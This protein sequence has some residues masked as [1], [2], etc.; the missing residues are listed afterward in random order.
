MPELPLRFANTLFINAAFPLPSRHARTLLPAQTDLNLVEVF[1]GRAALVVSFAL[2]RESPFGTYSEAVIALMA[3][4]TQTT[5]V[6]TLARLIQESRYPAYVLH[7]LVN[8]AQAQRIGDEIWSLPRSAATVE[9]EERGAQTMCQASL[10]GQS[11]VQLAVDRPTTD[12]SRSM[13]V[14]TYSQR[15]DELLLSVMRCEAAA[16]GRTQGGGAVLSW[17][18]HPIAEHLAAMHV[19]PQPLMVRYYDAMQAEL[20]A[21]VV[22]TVRSNG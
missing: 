19:S 13:Q 18:T 14:E 5:P 8:S 6:M 11:V 7:M 21:P 1:P 3:S 2:Y 16:Y 12:R 20:D 15:E 4:H 9:L 22:C 10:D 17:G